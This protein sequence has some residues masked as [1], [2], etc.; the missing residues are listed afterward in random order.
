MGRLK[1]IEPAFQHPCFPIV[2]SADQGVSSG[3][4]VSD[5]EV[6]QGKQQPD[7]CQKGDLQVL[8]KTPGPVGPAHR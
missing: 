7:D 4:V 1:A 6:G 5:S 3:P 8:A 2:L